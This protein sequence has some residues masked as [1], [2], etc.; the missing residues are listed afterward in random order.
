[1]DRSALGNKLVWKTART[2]GGWNDQFICSCSSPGFTGAALLA[3]WHSTAP[4][5][6]AVLTGQGALY[7][8]HLHCCFLGVLPWTWLNQHTP[9]QV[10]IPGAGGLTMASQVT[11][12][13]APSLN[14]GTRASWLPA[15]LLCPG[16]LEWVLTLPPQGCPGPRL[17][18]TLLSQPQFPYL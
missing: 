13:A 7:R 10:H 8:P 3:A 2:T 15:Q 9:A 11:V 17:V 6:F 5:S 18:T 1:M 14:L 12:D 4:Y 16:L